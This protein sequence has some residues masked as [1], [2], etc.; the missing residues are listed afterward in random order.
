[1]WYPAADAKRRAREVSVV[2][3]RDVRLV[4]NVR[5]ERVIIRIR[6]EHERLNDALGETVDE[7]KEKEGRSQAIE[8]NPVML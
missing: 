3:R 7:S 1:M 8:S 4:D 5:D 6:A 2:S